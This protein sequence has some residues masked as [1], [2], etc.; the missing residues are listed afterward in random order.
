MMKKW[1][2]VL[3]FSCV[4]IGSVN[5]LAQQVDIDATCCSYDD[6]N[7]VQ[8]CCESDNIN[9]P[10]VV[11][12]EHRKNIQTQERGCCDIG[13]PMG[14]MSELGKAV[15]ITKLC[16][17]TATK[18]E[19]PGNYEFVQ[20]KADTKECCIKKTARRWN[21][22][23]GE[24]GDSTCCENIG[25]EWGGYSCCEKGKP[26]DIEKGTV[27]QNCCREEVG[28]WTAFANK[29]YCCEN[30]TGKTW[31]GKVEKACCMA[32]AGKGF[33]WKNDTCC[34]P[35]FIDLAGG[36]NSKCCAGDTYQPFNY[37][38]DGEVSF[39]TEGISKQCC[40]KER[41]K[42]SVPNTNGGELCC[43]TD[44]PVYAS[45][46]LS[47]GSAA[48]GF[49]CCP[50]KSVVYKP[51]PSRALESCC[52]G[53]PY[54]AYT[55][56]TPSPGPGYPSSTYESYKCCEDPK[57]VTMLG[58]IGVCCKEE[59][60]GYLSSEQLGLCCGKDFVVVPSKSGGSS[61][62]CRP[63]SSNNSFGK[64]KEECC[65]NAGGTFISTNSSGGGSD[66]ADTGFCC[67]G[68]MDLASGERTKECCANA[69]GKWMGTFCC[70]TWGKKVN[71]ACEADSLP[72]SG[73][74]GAAGRDY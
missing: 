63:K 57:K 14:A 1:G 74:G 36:D 32:I 56:V 51:D 66:V 64:L 45:S 26:I 6:M 19:S 5:C 53:T 10:G 29:G 16:C 28:K 33:T 18:G 12:F 24:G 71:G 42:K 44:G 4:L 27:T 59:E 35:D 3:F 9:M 2:F 21:Q 37:R 46:D 60:N 62:C 50:E 17:E 11:Y 47:D 30:G 43:L 65:Q 13:T 49:S 15:G 31:D 55:G 41:F 70:G 20:P 8:R 38:Y 58:T 22:K 67:V 48:I 69:S 39:Y 34:S 61:E 72:D 7:L 52:K 23:V 54:K 68:S 25:G 73:S 40:P